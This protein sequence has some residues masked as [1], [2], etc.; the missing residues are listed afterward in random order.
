MRTNDNEQIGHRVMNLNTGKAVARGHV[1]PVPS[2]NTVKTAVESVAMQQGVNNIKFTNEKGVESP[3]VDWIAGVNHD[4]DWN[5][6]DNNDN[7]DN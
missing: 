4:P 5:Q 6:N 7:E 1:T 2:T 3:N